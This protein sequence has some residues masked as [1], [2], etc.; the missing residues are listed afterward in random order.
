MIL[1]LALAVFILIHAEVAVAGDDSIRLTT[2][3]RAM[4]LE[5][6]LMSFDGEFFRIE[7]A[8]GALTLDGGNVTCDGSGCP[9]PSELVAEA[10]ISG[11]SDMINR[12]MPPLLDAFAQREGY[13]LSSTYISDDSLQWTLTDSETGHVVARIDA[14]VETSREALAR[15]A[16]RETD[17]ALGR[18]EP[19]QNLRG[20]VIAL[21]ALVPVV[22]AANPITTLTLN[23]LQRLLSGRIK[24][25]DTIG[26]PDVPVVLHL[27]ANDGARA[28]LESR[29][30]GQRIRFAEGTMHDDSDTLADAVAS[31]PA[32]LG[33]SQLSL[34][35]NAVPIVVG[36]R[37]GLA[38]PAT[39]ASVKAEDYP[40]T[41]P[42]FLNRVGARQ[43]RLIRDF[44][45]FARSHEAQQV[46]QAAGFIDQAISQ[47]PFDQQGGRIAN[48]VLN[49]S[50]DAAA[51]AEVQRMIEGLR[52]G[53][54]LSLTF[55]FQD[56]SSDLDTQSAS[57]I[58][59]L[60]DAVGRGDFDAGELVFVG[61][62]DGL[63]EA[64]AN[65]RLSTRRAE[66]VRDAVAR[67]LDA[68]PVTLS[69]D[70][71][72]EALPMACDD[73]PWGRQVNRRVEVW[74]R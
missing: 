30:T 13:T 57:N 42:L 15:L 37:C 68:E 69:V 53:A 49:A 61:F 23:Q 67:L 12:L 26:G 5:G 2:L 7:T 39:R 58:R 8:Y 28:L 24:S 31:D 73:T 33:L 38:T 54:R 40:L 20:D 32:A 14:N 45:A 66:S 36:G 44:I 27:P 25:W 18:D 48:A 43:P 56:G 4:T 55:R 60:A 6:R 17:I 51:I 11:P 71:F 46:I 65:Q 35:G 52:G 16:S 9:D 3:D 10:R 50:D 34:I 29:V 74:L 21:D 41:Q 63:G 47:L 1:R 59:R 62:S 72:G 22:A 64:D 19:D 70:G